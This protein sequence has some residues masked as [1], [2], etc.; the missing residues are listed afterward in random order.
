MFTYKNKTYK[1][2]IWDWLYTL[3]NPDTGELYQWVPSFFEKLDPATV[4]YLVSFAKH[5]MLREKKIKNSPIFS[6]LKKL[7]IDID[8][9]KLAFQK[10]AADENLNPDDVLVIGD[11]ISHEG[12]AALIMHY[13]FVHVW[14]FAKELGF[15]HE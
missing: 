11:N 10:L 15:T 7:V 13:D 5:P 1:V 2:I 14:D 8:D 3:F 12:Q 4:N 6:R 9:K